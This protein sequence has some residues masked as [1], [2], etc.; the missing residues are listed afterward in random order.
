MSADMEEKADTE[1]VDIETV[2]NTVT[3]TSEEE[4]P[5]VTP[6]TWTVV[7]VSQ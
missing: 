7:A 3:P 4:V 1:N 6:K 5:V 2:E